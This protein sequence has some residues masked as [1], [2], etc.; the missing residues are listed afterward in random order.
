[1]TNDEILKIFPDATEDQ[2]SA[3]LSNNSDDDVQ[4]ALQRAKDAEKS[5]RIQKNRLDVERQFLK[6]GIS[7]ED[8][9]KLLDSIVSEDGKKSSTSAEAFISILTAQKKKTEEEVKAELLKGTPRP[10]G[11]KDE[12]DDD[13][14]GEALAKQLGADRAKTAEAASESM[15]HYIGG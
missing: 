2:I 13:S 6:A 4:A 14:E 1:M 15:K 5:F 3:L 9:S 8:Y 7:E 12:E 11:G 10:G